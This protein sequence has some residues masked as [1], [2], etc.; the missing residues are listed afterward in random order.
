MVQHKNL[1]HHVAQP[2]RQEVSA[3]LFEV[4]NAELSEGEIQH[5]KLAQAYSK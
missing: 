5:K 3:G 2:S 1:I 4:E